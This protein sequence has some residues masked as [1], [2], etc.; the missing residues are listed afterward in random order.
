MNPWRVATVEDDRV[1]IRVAEEAHVA[2]AGVVCALVE[3]LDTS[4]FEFLSCSGDVRDADR[5]ACHVRLER[6]ALL[7]RLPE[8]ERYVGR[9]DLTVRVLGLRETKHVAVEGNRTIEVARRDRDEVDALDLE[10]AGLSQQSPPS[11]AGSAGSSR[12]RTRAGAP[13]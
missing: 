1:P 5:E 4:A 3:E 12:P 8:R 11:G 7:L 2:N 13:S 9:L 10:R 6:E